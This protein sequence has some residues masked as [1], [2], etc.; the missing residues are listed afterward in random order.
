MGLVLGGVL[1]AL[2]ITVLML[3]FR[4]LQRA[5][6][7]EDRLN[8]MCGLPG[9]ATGERSD[10]PMINARVAD[11]FFLPGLAP[12]SLAGRTFLVAALAAQTIVLA[13]A[14]WKAGIAIGIAALIG[15]MFLVRWRKKKHAQEFCDGLPALLER[16][17]RLILIGNTLPQA[18]V[19]AVATADP[20]VKREIDP[21]VRRIRHGASFADSIEMLARQID[22]IEL[23]MLAAYVRTNA[24]F[25]GRVAQT[26]VNLIN[27]LA[28]K[29]RLERE[30]KAATA[31]T[32]ASAIILFGLMAFTMTAMSLMNPEYLRFFLDTDTG[33]IFLIGII[34]WPLLGALVMRRILVIDF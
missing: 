15:H 18:F 13:F 33:R 17:R 20:I 31:E 14:G 16:T 21:V 29:R 5:Q 8:A 28:N 1:G 23:H 11:A 10:T 30:I 25:G 7:L 2:A 34:G 3:G 19:E 12:Q 9:E 6:R 4:G 24:K 26:L 27:Q 22:I 32:R